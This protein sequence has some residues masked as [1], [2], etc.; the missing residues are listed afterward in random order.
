MPPRDEHPTR[1]Q[2]KFI[3]IKQSGNWEY[4]TRNGPQSAVAIVAITDENKVLMVEQFRVPVGEKVIE[5]PAGLAGDVAGSE[6]EALVSAAQREL[7]EETG[8]EA[9]EWT[10]LCASYSTPGLAD[11]RIVFFLARGLERAG[12]GG[13]DDAEEIE[14]LEVPL[15]EVLPWLQRHQTTVDIKLMAGLYAAQAFLGRHDA[16]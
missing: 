5:L 7:L 3:S 10:E 9:R 16:Y 12:S 8:Y 2:G 13:G 1:W 6:D 4:V 15:D 14:V 11:E